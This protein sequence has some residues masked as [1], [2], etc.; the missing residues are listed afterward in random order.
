M[1]D[2]AWGSSTDGAYDSDSA[3]N[4]YVAFAHR[5]IYDSCKLCKVKTFI[6]NV[7]GGK[8]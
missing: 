1:V 8:G 5:N 4:C 6:Y 3:H 2:I 7:S